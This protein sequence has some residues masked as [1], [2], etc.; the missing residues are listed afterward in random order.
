MYFYSIFFNAY[1]HFIFECIHVISYN[2]RKLALL[3]DINRQYKIFQLYIIYMKKIH[4][5]F[6]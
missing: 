5:L 3:Y 1:I 4:E 2:Q 6:N